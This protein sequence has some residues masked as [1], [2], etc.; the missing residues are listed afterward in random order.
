MKKLLVPLALVSTTA[1][2][3]SGC[4]G[5]AGGSGSE[6][7]SGDGFTY[8]APQ[9]DVD[10]VLADLDPV[11][12]T[13][14]PPAS[15]P[16]SI[17]A[18][19]ANAYKEYIEERSGGKITLD[20]V[21][22]QAIAGYGEVDDALADGRLD[23][24]YS[25]PIYNPTEYPSFDAAA[26]SLSSL[27]ISPV[28]GEAVYNAVSAEIGWQS[29]GLLDEYEAQGVVPLTPIIASGGYYSVCAD[30]G[31]E[32]DD[33]SGRQVRVA[34]TA[35]LGV[36]EALHASPVSMEYVEV[37]EALQRGTVN[38]TFAQLLPSAESGI[39][40]VAPHISYS[41]DEFSMSSRAVGAELAGSSFTQLPLAYQQIIFD[42]ASATF[43]GIVGIVADGNTESVRQAKEAGGSVEPFDPA[44]EEII[45]GAQ[46][47]QME[48]VKENGLLGDD[49]D[50]R[51]EESAQK[52]SGVAEQ[53][54]LEDGGTF[55]DLD[56]WWSSD[57]MD[58]TPM[59]EQLF[60]EAFTAHRP[61]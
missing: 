13:Y 3:V 2:L 31:S 48:A 60:E 23:L 50:A 47:E 24:A 44:T 25:L 58:F 59:G 43:D 39:L 15:S 36:V 32:P 56:E 28:V 9:E 4:A 53:L 61:Q 46:S 27:P 41:S 45:A 33:W 8:G 11:T 42:A 37:F 17:M 14:Q 18:P 22:G 40:E 20:V 30:P 5:G 6:S 54:G 12:L 51:I 57:S 34:S 16:N 7:A 35:H 29:E 55:E 21:W 49:I 26:T 19:A 1:L 10:A 38:C 52:W